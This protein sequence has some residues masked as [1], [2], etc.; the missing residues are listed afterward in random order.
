MEC[1]SLQAERFF[2]RQPAAEPEH[3]GCESGGDVDADHPGDQRL[4]PV[5]G[6]VPVEAA[7]EFAAEVKQ[8]EECP[9]Q[10]IG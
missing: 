5:G 7:G 9:G 8:A 10:E 1:G 6:F 3:G 2:N 4:L